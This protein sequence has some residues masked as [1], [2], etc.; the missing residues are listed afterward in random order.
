MWQLR[1]VPPDAVVVAKTCRQ[2]NCSHHHPGGHLS[3]LSFCDAVR[4]GPCAYKLLA[5]AGKDYKNLYHTI[6]M[7]GIHSSHITHHA[8]RRSWGSASTSQPL[9]T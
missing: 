6:G 8:L 4:H 7:D 1:W 3:H 2:L 5:L 9:S